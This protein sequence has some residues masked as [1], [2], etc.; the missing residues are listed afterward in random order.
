MKIIVIGELCLDRF[1]Y[2]ETKRLSPEAPVPILT[3][4]EMTENKGMSGNVVENLKSLN[5]DL[6]II[7]WYQ[8]KDI[9]KTRYVDKKSNHM[10]LRVDEGETDIKP[11]ELNTSKL[12]ELKNVDAVIISDYNKGF[13]NDEL[14]FEITKHTQFSIIDTKKQIG[15]DL[16]NKFD[17]VKLN[18]SE[19]SKHNLNG[20]SINKLLITLGSNGAKYR[21]KIYPSPNPKETI[22]V[23]GA[24]DTFTSSFTLKYLE[25][26]DVEE[27]IIFANKMA[28]IVVS[29]RGVTTPTTQFGDGVK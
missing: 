5:K 26:K 23:S 4:I 21:D 29:K 16:I 24:G 13:L 15:D 20:N 2:V 10:F 1:I 7:H 27:S 3:P 28:S 9:T 18:E 11:L 14:L 8:D 17:F 12:N 6:H 19:F 22:D 25:T